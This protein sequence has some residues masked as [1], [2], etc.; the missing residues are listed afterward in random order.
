[1]ALDI[2]GSTRIHRRSATALGGKPSGIGAP[3]TLAFLDPPY[4]KG[5]VAPALQALKEGEWLE[6]GAFIVVEQGKGEDAPALEGF[7]LEDERLFGDT[8]IRFLRSLQR[9]K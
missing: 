1:E 4:G 9:S 5:F 8:V 3:F 7:I 2:I 6:E